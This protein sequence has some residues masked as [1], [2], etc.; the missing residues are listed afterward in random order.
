MAL[1]DVCVYVCGWGNF[2]F[3]SID[4]IAALA[5]PDLSLW[6]G[7]HLLTLGFGPAVRDL[8]GSPFSGG[9]SKTPIFF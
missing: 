1:C 5:R 8:R 4:S 7:S 3:S 2:S 9:S 6:V